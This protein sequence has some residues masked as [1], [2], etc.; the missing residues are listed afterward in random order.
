MGGNQELRVSVLRKTVVPGD[1]G[2]SNGSGGTG[3]RFRSLVSR[4]WYVQVMLSEASDRVGG[5]KRNEA[6]H[7]SKERNNHYIFSTAMKF[8]SLSKE[9]HFWEDLIIVVI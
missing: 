6:R 5:T 1:V 3:W 2:E 7:N 9:N 4:T 8:S